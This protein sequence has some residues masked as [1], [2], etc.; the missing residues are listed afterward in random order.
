M[1]H[2]VV[3]EHAVLGAVILNP[4]IAGPALLDL[5]TEEFTPG[6]EQALAGLLADMLRRG[7]HIDLLTIHSEI[8]SRGLRP[9][10]LTRTWLYDVTQVCM[11]P[12]SAAAYAVQ[13]REI[14]RHRTYLAAFERGT[15]KLQRAAETGERDQLDEIVAASISELSRVPEPLDRTTAEPPRTLEDLLAVQPTF[16]WLVPHLLERG[17]RLMLTGQEGLGKVCCSDN[18]EH[19]SPLVSTHSPAKGS[20]PASV[21][22]TLMRRTGSGSHVAHT[23]RSRRPSRIIHRPSIGGRI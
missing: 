5:A 2:D 3:S 10:D 11:D 23:R 13:V 14:H 20:A 9:N 19:A 7:E 15:N 21:S 16:D 1:I 22:C 17:E 6:K 8:T 4:K 18:S 12:R